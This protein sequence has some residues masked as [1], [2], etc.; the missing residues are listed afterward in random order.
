MD[1]SDLVTEQRRP[2]LDDLDRWDTSDLVALM[3]RDQ[4]DVV[5]A[6]EAAAA[7]IAAAVDAVVQRLRR[8][9]RLI[10]VGAGTAGRL[11]LL[12]AVECPPTFATD[13]V[14]GVLAGGDGAVP[15]SHEA[16]EDDAVAGGRDLAARAVDESDA[17]VG[18]AASGRTPYTLGAVGEARRRGALT[19]G[20]SC[21]AGAELSRRVDHPIEVVVGPEFIAGST[22]LKAGSAQKI[23]LNTLS[24][25]AMVRLGKTFGD[26]MVDVRASNEKLRHRAQRI[27]GEATGADTATAEHALAAATGH[28]KTAIVM[29]LGGVDAEEA[30]RRLS[31]HDGVVRAAVE[32]GR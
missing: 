17:V 32:A 23:V 8:G 18:I 24:T 11:G 6:V 31:A 2:G 14:V 5:R 19:I 28:V 13:R 29:L 21:N 22:R 10:Y 20:V 4:L 15:V 7:P 3:A 12:D 25:V 30:G 16:I 9:G 26:L 27:V 1:L